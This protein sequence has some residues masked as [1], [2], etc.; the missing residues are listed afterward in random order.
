MGITSDISGNLYKKSEISFNLGRNPYETS[1]KKRYLVR[2]I[3]Y[4]SDLPSGC[5]TGT[6]DKFILFPP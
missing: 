4:W 3:S 6:W 1:P 2:W 5:N